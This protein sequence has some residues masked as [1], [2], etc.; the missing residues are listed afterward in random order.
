MPK[1]KPKYNLQSKITS[2][3]RKVWRY[4]PER[5]ECVNAA[6]DPNTPKHSIC[7]ECGNIVNTKLTAIDHI[8]P[9]VSEEGFKDWDTFVSRLFCQVSNLRCLCE[10]CHAK[11]TKQQAAAKKAFKK[12]QKK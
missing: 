4:S 5:L 6:K 8:V 2:A 11:I 1:A 3:L 12:E 7:Q 9:V 10:G